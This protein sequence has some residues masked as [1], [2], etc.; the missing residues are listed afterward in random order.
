MSAFR[1]FLERCE[2]EAEREFA[3]GLHEWCESRG[4]KVGCA[5]RGSGTLILVDDPHPSGLLPNSYDIA[6][7]AKIGRYRLDFHIWPWLSG[8][9]RWTFA[10]EIDGH[11]WHERSHQEA[12]AQRRRDR[13]C[14]TRE[15]FTIRFAAIEVFN[16]RLAVATE[17]F[18]MIEAIDESETEHIRT[19]LPMEEL[20][21]VSDA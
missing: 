15:I 8:G 2:S 5:R 10:V 1:D 13:W 19:M 3:F 21:R 11:A 20:A 4:G 9:Q 18:E 7:Q 17:L 16:D 6:A 14:A 12:A